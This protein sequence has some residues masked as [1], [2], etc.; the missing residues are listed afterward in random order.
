MS[1]FSYKIS[2]SLSVF[3]KQVKVCFW[4]F[5]NPSKDFEIRDL[6][7]F[8][9]ICFNNEADLWILPTKVVYST[10]I[11]L[12]NDTYLLGGFLWWPFGAQRNQH[13]ERNYHHLPPHST[14]RFTITFWALDGWEYSPT[15]SS[16]TDGAKISFDSQSPMGLFGLRILDYPTKAS[17]CGV[18]NR[19]DVRDIFI[20]GSIPHSGSSLNFTIISIMTA[21]STDESFGFRDISLIFSESN[22]TPSLCGQ[23]LDVPFYDLTPCPCLKGFY[24]SG[25]S[26]TV[27]SECHENC[28]SCFGGSENDCYECKEGSYFDGIACRKC[29]NSCS[30]CSGPDYNQCESCNAGYVSFENICIASSRCILPFIDDTCSNSCFSPCDIVDKD[31]WE[32]ECFPPCPNGQIS[33]FEGFCHSKFIS[34]HLFFNL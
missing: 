2:R 1:S 30:R 10:R 15:T 5:F 7:K 28:A 16:L 3:F 31:A 12:C 14:L 25:T 33:D 24:N 17:L 21:N 34:F 11:Y 19:G 9:H 18:P 13:F 6:E 32:E 23:I 26:S 27:C 8:D 4:F 20:F 29:H 22:D